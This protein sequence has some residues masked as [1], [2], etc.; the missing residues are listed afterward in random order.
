MGRYIV[1]FI[2]TEDK[3]E[4]DQSKGGYHKLWQ[5]NGLVEKFPVYRKMILKVECLL[6][7]V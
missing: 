2:H 7:L 1:A 6:V 3:T 4:V 5:I